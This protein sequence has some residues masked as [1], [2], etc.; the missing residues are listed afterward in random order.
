M[1]RALATLLCCLSLSLAAQETPRLDETVDVSI[2]NVDVVVTDR[3]GNPVH[4]LTKDDFELFE[5]GKQQP[6]SNFAEYTSDDAA[7]RVSAAGKEPDVPREKRTFLVFF[8]K[9]QLTGFGADAIA[10]A[11]KKTIAELVRPGDTVSVV[12]W[13]RHDIEHF[14]AGDDPAKIAEAIDFVN[15]KSK[16]IHLDDREL[17]SVERQQQRE[18]MAAA[19]AV[20][21]RGQS[22][23]ALSGG[24]LDSNLIMQM[25][26]H[27]MM[28]RVAAINASINSIAG[29]DGKKI[30]LLAP[31]RLGEVAGAE[32][33][34]HEGTVLMPAHLRAQ[35]GTEQL[36]QSIV[37]NANAAGITI[38]PVFP[39]GLEG[40]GSGADQLTFGNEMIS[41]R[42]IAAATGGVAAG[43]PTNVVNLLP[44]ITTDVNNYYS[45]A[46]RVRSDGTDR[47]RD[48]VV[49]ARSPEYSVR[50][51][52]QFVEKSDETRMRDRL[53]ATL[54]RETGDADIDI[55]VAT[56]KTTKSSR[57][58]TVPVEVTIPI[59]Q[60][61][62]L[63]DGKTH[64]GR[65]SV[66]IGVATE[67]N[68]LSDVT[69]KTQPFTVTAAQF[70][71]AM[72]SHFTYEMDVKV[73]GRSKYLAVG[74]FD[75]VG[76]TYGL[77]R[78][79][80]EPRQ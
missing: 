30:L 73:N 80:L 56:G 75:E 51:R 47:E 2:V 33:V 12:Y 57:T 55:A 40:S 37:D 42:K 9:M 5:H 62:L 38:Y 17:F 19:P 67:L 6:V 59:K 8:E 77:Q 18:L 52:T 41:L 10:A 44:Q 27:D 68:E 15:A 21:D 13:S 74:V 24:V 45:L 54:F 35:Y 3:K 69:Q 60:L 29:V 72:E 43:G 53:K 36:I 31:R 25:A 71:K 28:L 65:F 66:Y 48:I 64:S 23:P 39:I 22:A 26:Y 20:G 49:K 78:I 32:H 70:E 16:T 1:K 76:R 63:D 46:Y 58:Y 50:A 34:Y 7:A 79:E 14:E 4:G 61:T 11:L